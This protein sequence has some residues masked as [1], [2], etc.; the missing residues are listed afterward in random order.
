MVE[1]PLLFPPMVLNGIYSEI[2]IMFDVAIQISIYVFTFLIGHFRG[3][4]I[5]DDNIL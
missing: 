4:L 2:E 1:I 5:F 3:I